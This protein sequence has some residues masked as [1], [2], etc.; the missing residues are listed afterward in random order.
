MVMV[1]GGS[2]WKRGRVVGVGYKWLCVSREKER[3]NL[4]IRMVGRL[5][6][7]KIVVLGWV[8]LGCC[9]DEK[10]WLKLKGGWKVERWR[11]RSDWRVMM[12]DDGDV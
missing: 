2:R 10:W 3:N 7:G 6:R 4:G 9:W 12:M 5:D 8:V 11:W 1:I